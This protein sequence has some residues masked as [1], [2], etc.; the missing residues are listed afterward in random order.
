MRDV[1][2]K[3]TADEPLFVNTPDLLYRGIEWQRS[4]YT[5]PMRISTTGTSPLSRKMSSST[6]TFDLG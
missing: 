2:G 6:E 3:N 1:A 5:A 4:S